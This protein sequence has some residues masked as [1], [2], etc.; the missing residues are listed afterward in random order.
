[1]RPIP[2]RFE[3]VIPRSLGPGERLDQA[4]ENQLVS[5]A[6]EDEVDVMR[7][8][9]GQLDLKVTA[10]VVQTRRMAEELLLPAPARQVEHLVSR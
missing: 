8:V 1:V 3:K 10:G 7:V 9:T 2:S 5:L 4:P 6:F